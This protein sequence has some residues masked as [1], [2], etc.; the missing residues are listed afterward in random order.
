MKYLEETFQP[1]P[2]PRNPFPPFVYNVDFIVGKSS[3]AEKE[4]GEDIQRDDLSQLKS[5]IYNFVETLNKKIRICVC[6]E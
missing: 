3:K 4:E 6:G 1:F 5:Y 2:F